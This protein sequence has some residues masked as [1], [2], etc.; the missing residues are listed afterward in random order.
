MQ[1]I[2]KKDEAYAPRRNDTSQ[3]HSEEDRVALV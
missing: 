1:G 2:V 3:I